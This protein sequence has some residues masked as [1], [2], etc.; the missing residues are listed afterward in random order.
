MLVL[1]RTPL[2]YAIQGDGSQAV[3][4][5]LIK[6]GADP[7]KAANRGVTPLHCAARKGFLCRC[8]SFFNTHIMYSQLQAGADVITNSHVKPLSVAAHKGLADCIQC[9]LEA[10]ADPNERDE[11]GKLPIEVAASRGREKC[12]EI[13]LRVTDPLPKYEGLSISEMITNEIPIRHHEVRCSIEEGD[14]AY[15]GKEYA[16]ALRCYT[17]ALRLGIDDES[18]LY[19]KRSLCHLMTRDEERYLDDAMVYVKLLDSSL[20]GFLTQADVK[21]MVLVSYATKS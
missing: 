10:G 9:L 17:K 15:W 20:S 8:I 21:R 7:N 13:L 4:E 5:C 14:T 1:G 16:R 19:A 6:K 3:V 11:D 18:E 2:Y 12:V